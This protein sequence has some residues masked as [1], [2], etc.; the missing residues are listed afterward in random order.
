VAVGACAAEGCEGGRGVSAALVTGASRRV[1]IA[2]AVARALARDGWDVATTC[3]RP[4][5]ETEPWGSGAREAEE[6]VAELRELGVRS[7]LHEDDLADVAAPAR[8][9]DAAEG[10]V[11]PLTALV[12]VHAHSEQGGLLDATAEQFDR[13]LAVNARATLLL[14]A[15]FA[16]RFRGGHGSGRIVNFSSGLPLAGEIAYAASKGAVEWLTVSAAVE[17]GPRGITA[18]AIDPGP[19]DTGWMP[20]ELKAEIEEAT[21]L[22]RAGRPENAAELVAFLCSP[23]GG[24]ITG[25]VLRS[26]GGFSHVGVSRRGRDLA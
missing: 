13:H 4:Y 5:D 1:G 21:P 26:D 10:S 6:L 18:N 12:N 3:W 2:A 25:Q 17:L 14:C 9:L 7:G 16:R 8:V 22:G 24:W 11:G 20:P 19:T 15:E 23:A